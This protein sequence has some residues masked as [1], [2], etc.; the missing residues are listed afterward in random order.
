MGRNKLMQLQQ[1]PEAKPRNYLADMVREYGMAGLSDR[2][3]SP[4]SGVGMVVDAVGGLG[5]ALFVQPAQSWNRLLSMGYQSG[6]PQG[7]EDAF[8]VS[9]AAMLGGIAAPRP[10]ASLNAGLPQ[11]I[12]SKTGAALNAAGK[13]QPIRAYHG[14]PHDFDRFDMSKIGTGEGA[15]A[16]GHGLYF[17]ENEG[18]ASQYRHKLADRPTITVGGNSSFKPDTPEAIVSARLSDYTKRRRI[19]GEDPT[20]QESSAAVKEELDRHIARA[21]QSNDFDLYKSL[22]DQRLALDRMSETGIDMNRPGRLYEVRI[23]AN[24]D[25]F[26]DWDKPLSQ[27]S[28]KVRGALPS[29]LPADMTG[30]QV[31]NEV[32]QFL[33]QN[34]PRNFTDVPRGSFVNFDNNRPEVASQISSKLR[35][36]GVPGIKY[37]DQGSRTQGEGSRNYVVFD[38]KLVEILRKYGLLGMIGGGAVAAGAEADRKPQSDWASRMQPGDA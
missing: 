19:F 37:L 38:D 35:E 6:D 23:N 1:G 22:S 10:R 30:Q 25:D 2:L 5:N 24:P 16:Y 12:F 11:D 20:P 18:V 36:Q 29:D 13:R 32:R 4:T 28:E 27:Q 9:G 8:N 33:M 26:L 3:N 31:F 34:Q 21:A 17:A 14:S 15:Q 7:A